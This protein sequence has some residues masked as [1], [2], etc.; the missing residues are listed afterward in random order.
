M[1]KILIA[2]AKKQLRGKLEGYLSS[3]GY[4]VIEAGTKDETLKFVALV[5]PSLILVDSALVG[6]AVLLFCQQLRQMQA[7][8]LILLIDRGEKELGIQ[9]LEEGNDDLISKPLHKRELLARVKAVLRRVN[10]VDRV[11]ERKSLAVENL[12]IDMEKQE[13][14][15]FGRKVVLT[16]KELDLLWLLAAN[17]NQV[18]SRAQLLQKIWGMAPRQ[19]MR[20]V[21]TH[22]KSLRQKL[23]VVSDSLWNIT[24]V[25][26]V[27]YKFAI[28]LD[29]EK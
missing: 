14:I 10:I 20:T 3:E 11:E 1:Y 2:T 22:I 15:A 25:W 19:D 28:E 27:G 4:E 17:P 9:G 5:K 21:D 18:F 29:G 23:N 16:P 7:A 6:N 24:T 12:S 13:V 8:G 26:S